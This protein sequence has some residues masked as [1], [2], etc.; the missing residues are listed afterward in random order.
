MI[1]DFKTYDKPKGYQQKDQHKER[2]GEADNIANNANTRKIISEA[3]KKLLRNQT[4]QTIKQTR[5]ERMNRIKLK[6]N[7]KLTKKKKNLIYSVRL[8]DLHKSHKNDQ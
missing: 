8:K 3:K 6:E 4:K 1:I 7:K 5:K 2:E